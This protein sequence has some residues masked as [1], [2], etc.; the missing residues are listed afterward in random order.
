[1]IQRKLNFC[2]YIYKNCLKSANQLS[3]IVRPRCFLGNEEKKVLTNG[4]VFSNFNYCPL[5]WTLANAKYVHKV[6]AIQK[7]AL[8]FTLNDHES[9]YEDLLKRSRKPSTNLRMTMTLCI[10]IYKIINNLNPEFMKNLFKFIK[11]IQH[12]NNSTRSNPINPKSNQVSF[13]TKSLRV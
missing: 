7:R 6:E 8:R 10:E 12:R 11:L 5:F 2:L 3:G 1:M 13:G 4:L 9:Y